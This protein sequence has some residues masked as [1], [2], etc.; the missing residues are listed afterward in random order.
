MP[1]TSTPWRSLS[2]PTTQRVLGTLLASAE[3][4]LIAALQW[5]LL[6][7]VFGSMSLV[8]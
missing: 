6:L 5:R 3:P 1:G 7:L 4:L 8:R 2:D